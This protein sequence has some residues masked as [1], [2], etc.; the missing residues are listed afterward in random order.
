MKVS[1]LDDIFP[2]NS[3]CYKNNRQP[4]KIVQYRVGR[5]FKDLQY[6]EASCFDTSLSGKSVRIYARYI[7]DPFHS[8]H[9]I[10]CHLRTRV[11]CIHHCSSFSFCSHISC[12]VYSLHEC[13]AWDTNP[14][15]TV[16]SS[17]LGGV[18]A[19]RGLLRTQ[20]L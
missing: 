4:L 15:F 7:R 3:M 9:S 16:V 20:P 6:S 5:S 12:L 13:A 14:L 11:P 18:C 10:S 17:T 19:L 1:K 8:L 2:W